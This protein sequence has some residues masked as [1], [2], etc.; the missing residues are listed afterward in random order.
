MSA[1]GVSRLFTFSG[2]PHSA[3]A[4]QT[5]PRYAESVRAV[6]SSI[7]AATQGNLESEPS[8]V[9]LK[10]GGIAAWDAAPLQ[11][12]E[13]RV[14]AAARS[15]PPSRACREPGTD[16]DGGHTR[17]GPDLLREGIDSIESR[18]S[19][20]RERPPRPSE[21]NDATS[22]VQHGKLPSM[23]AKPYLWFHSGSALTLQAV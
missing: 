22:G 12:G 19:A 14:P 10:G 3:G 11:E 5:P 17:P 9:A 13:L 6:L 23:P 20:A 2:P 1:S 4:C 7:G 16:D 18:T 8:R 21:K 15:T